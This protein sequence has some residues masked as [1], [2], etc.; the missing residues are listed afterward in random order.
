MTVVV[1]GAM[2]GPLEK[3][4]RNQ[5]NEL[6]ER[7]GGRSSSSVSKKTTLVVAGENAG[8]KRAKAETLGIRLATTDEFATLI[9]EY[10][11]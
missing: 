8:S 4:S 1:T 11:D 10:L 5:M 3:L 7:A 9:A 2:T 6:V